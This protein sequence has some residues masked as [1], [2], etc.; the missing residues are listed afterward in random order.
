MQR[1]QRGD[2]VKPTLPLQLMYGENPGVV[3]LGQPLAA[4]AHQYD[5]GLFG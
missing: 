4:D 2:E 5:L 3:A 1:S